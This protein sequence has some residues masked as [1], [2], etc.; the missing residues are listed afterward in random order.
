MGLYFRDIVTVALYILNYRFAKIS[1]IPGQVSF[2]EQQST[3]W[4]P[5]R[6]LQ[7]LG[8]LSILC[9]LPVH[10]EMSMLGTI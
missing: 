7:S 10:M 8:G 2:A 6:Q 1:R 4:D 9:Q 5:T 3:T